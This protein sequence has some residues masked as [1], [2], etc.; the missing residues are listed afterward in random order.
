M[1]VHGGGF[2]SMSSSSHQ[3]YLRQWCN[4]VNIPIFSVDYWLAPEH[5]FPCQLID[6]L[7]TYL[8]LARQVH[9]V[10]PSVKQHPR[11]ILAGDSAGGNLVAALLNLLISLQLHHQVTAVYCSYP[12]VDLDSSHFYPS[13]LYALDDPLLCY[14]FLKLCIASYVDHTLYPFHNYYISVIN[15]P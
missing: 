7:A 12:A 2:I 14:S 3:N 9:L 15:T 6:L 5:Q 11:V 4:N 10:L 1:H 13:L 8:F